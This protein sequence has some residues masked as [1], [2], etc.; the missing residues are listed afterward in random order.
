MRETPGGPEDVARVAG[1]PVAAHWSFKAPGYLAG[2]PVAIGRF[3]AVPDRKG[4]VHFLDPN[5]GKSRAELRAKGPGTG[6]LVWDETQLYVVSRHRGR[7]LQCFEFERGRLVWHRRYRQAPERPIRSGAE[8]WLPVHDTMFALD[9]ATGE[10]KRAI[11]QGGDAWL[12][13]ARWRSGWLVLGRFGTVVGLDSVGERLW[14]S[15][16]EASCA[17]RPAVAGDTAWVVTTEGSVSCLEAGGRVVW[18]KTLD[19]T[20]LFE[21]RV[22]AERLCVGAASG[23]V[24]MLDA[25]TGEVVWMREL[26][27]PLSGAPVL[28]PQWVAVTRRDGRLDILARES[29]ET[30]DTVSFES[31]LPFEPTWAF[32]RLYVVDSERK[33][34]ALGDRP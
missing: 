14:T 22:L 26:D 13:P 10:T 4:K 6:E 5:S 32:G 30:L 1:L 7:T 20:A 34:H 15:N 17:E 9:P 28:H 8:L 31:I 12:C 23:R 18:E 25:A 24:W 11:L 3:V 33:L 2:P 21:A 29:G 16:L 27:A 19:S